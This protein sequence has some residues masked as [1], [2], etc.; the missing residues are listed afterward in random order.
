MD[1][2]QEELIR[3]TPIG[4]ISSD[5]QLFGHLDYLLLGFATVPM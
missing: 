4:M 2:P 3:Y 1:D 5:T